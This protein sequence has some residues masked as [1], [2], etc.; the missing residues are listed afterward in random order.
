MNNLFMDSS[1]ITISLYINCVML[2]TFCVFIRCYCKI[3]YFSD[4]SVVY[5]QFG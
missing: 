3:R 5:L 2:K 1:G 4:F